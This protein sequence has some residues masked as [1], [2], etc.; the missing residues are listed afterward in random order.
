M[1][2]KGFAGTWK[3][4]VARSDL[5][6]VTKSQVLVIE[7]DGNAVTMREELANDR[8][9]TL[10][11]SVEGRFD[12]RDYPV[13]GTPFADTV[14]YRLLDPRTIEGVAKRDGRVCVRETAVLG[15]DGDTVH[16]TYRSVDGS[17][18]AASSHGVFE[19]IEGV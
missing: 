6:P 18:N 1:S 4:N 10:I 5:P 15:E 17:G 2:A 7:T 14:A 19:R 16:V 11:I 9:E 12:G 3:L 13:T 8:G